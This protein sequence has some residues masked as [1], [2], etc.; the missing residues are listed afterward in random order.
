MKFSDMLGPRP[1]ILEQGLKL[2]G[3]YKDTEEFIKAQLDWLYPAFTTLMNRLT[4][5]K[6]GWKS[7]GTVTEPAPAD[8][9]WSF[10]TIGTFWVAP[11]HESLHAHLGLVIDRNSRVKVVAFGHETDGSKVLNGFTTCGSA[12]NYGDVIEQRVQDIEVLRES[13]RK[14]RNFMEDVG[15]LSAKYDQLGFPGEQFGPEIG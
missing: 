4:E 9:I 12:D 11:L 7:I 6:S 8:E 5:G 10:L 14:T 1:A 13:W 2:D 15:K 3:N